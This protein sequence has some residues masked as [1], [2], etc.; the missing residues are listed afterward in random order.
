MPDPGHGSAHHFPKDRPCRYCAHDEGERT[1]SGNVVCWRDVRRGAYPRPTV[2]ARSEHGCCHW[3]RAPG[4]D[5]DL[6][7]PLQPTQPDRQ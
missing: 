4:A 7:S 1:R 3:T 6:E 5:D 2:I